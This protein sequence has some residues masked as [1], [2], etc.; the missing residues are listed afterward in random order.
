MRIYTLALSGLLLLGGAVNA[1]AFELRS[2]QG[3]RSDRV[4]EFSL[5]Q[6]GNEGGGCETNQQSGCDEQRSH[7][8]S[9]RKDQDLNTQQQHSKAFQQLLAEDS[10]GDDSAHRG[11]GRKDQ[12]STGDQSQS[13]AFHQLLAENS[14]SE[15]SAHRG[16]GRKEKE[17]TGEEA[18]AKVI[19]QLLAENSESE[20][21][22]HRG[23]GRKEKEST[24]EEA[25]AKG[26]HQLLAENSE[27]EESAHRGSGRKDQESTGD[28]AEAKTFQQGNEN[29]KQLLV[30]EGQ[31]ESNP[32]DGKS[33]GESE[34]GHRGS[35]RKDA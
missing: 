16:S 15:E 26:I 25:Q 35:G 31:D 13:K 34:E 28:E 33:D 24:G 30:A 4:Q 27:S 11:S 19:H 7:R 23:S 29:S 5:S 14:E 2:S 17:S 9:G 32:G 10:E 18:Q 3:D 1:Q 6:A 22:A 12:D 20:E 21:S 8:G